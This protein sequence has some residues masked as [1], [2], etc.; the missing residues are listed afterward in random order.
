MLSRAAGTTVLASPDFLEHNIGGTAA[1]PAGMSLR[2]ERHALM[3]LAICDG[4]W[5]TNRELDLIQINPPW[6]ST[7]TQIK[8][9]RL[10]SPRVGLA[11]ARS[12]G[13]GPV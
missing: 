12:F 10:D 1:F 4:F 8:N 2:F 13:L 9:A 11:G 6:L 3:D 7:L 5:R